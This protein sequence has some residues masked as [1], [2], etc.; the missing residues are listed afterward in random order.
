MN[1]R[2]PWPRTVEYEGQECVKI[3]GQ[4]KLRS[5]TKSLGSSAPGAEEKPL[6]AELDLSIEIY[7]SLELAIDLSVSMTGTLELSNTGD[8]DA[9]S[10]KASSPV[11][12]TRTLKKR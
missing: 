9:L 6:A 5:Q 12:F 2:S 1:S 4:G 8:E 3:T 7:R 11:E 10:Y